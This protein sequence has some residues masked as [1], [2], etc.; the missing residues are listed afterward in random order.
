MNR[1]TLLTAIIG[2]VSV[3][4]GCLQTSSSSSGNQTSSEQ[5]STP[6]SAP[7]NTEKSTTSPTADEISSSTSVPTGTFI[8]N[9]PDVKIFNETNTVLTITVTINRIPGTP[10]DWSSVGT[11]NRNDPSS[12]QTLSETFELSPSSPPEYKSKIYQNAFKTSHSYSIKIAVQDG[13]T[14]TYYLRS[15]FD[16]NGGLFIDI[17]KNSI[18]FVKGVA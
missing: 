16:H 14:N 3:L 10:I 17:K 8:Q 6:P 7:P 15:G 9:I 18:E 13:L 11:D 4:S 2:G 5:T 1:R 12:E